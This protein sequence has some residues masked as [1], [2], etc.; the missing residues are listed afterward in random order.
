VRCAQCDTSD[1]D[2]VGIKK[3]VE[4][5][6]VAHL[7]P[8][9]KRKRVSTAKVLESPGP[10]KK[11]K[12]PDLLPP[13]SDLIGT[14]IP[15]SHKSKPF[16]VQIPYETQ[17]HEPHAVDLLNATYKKH[18]NDKI[19]SP[20]RPQHNSVS[21]TTNGLYSAHP[22]GQPTKPP[23]VTT[24]DGWTAVNSTRTPL[25]SS[26]PLS[27]SS[28]VNG[29]SSQSQARYQDAEV[30]KKQKMPLIDTFSKTEQRQVYGLIHGLQGGIEA[31][32]KQLG[33]LKGLLGIEE[34]V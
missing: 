17:R 30:K 2:I 1:C 5:S 28:V 33:T 20:P 32:S 7:E 4:D 21:S 10:V 6:P 24:H 26:T 19:P 13:V 16:E 12:K 23:A 9:K 11:A 18:K 3:E 34:D 15:L 31:M 25:P 14:D 29:S 8:S 27:H 22:Y